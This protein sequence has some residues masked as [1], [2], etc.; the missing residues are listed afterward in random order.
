MTEKQVSKTEQHIRIV[1]DF[2][3][4]SDYL[5]YYCNSVLGRDLPLTSSECSSPPQDFHWPKTIQPCNTGTEAATLAAYQT[6]NQ[7]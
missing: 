3:K 4:L 6:P 7:T 2:L 1:Y 5:D